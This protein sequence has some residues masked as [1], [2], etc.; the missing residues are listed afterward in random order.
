MNGRASDIPM[1]QPFGLVT[2]PDNALYV[3]EVGSHVIR[4]IDLSTGLSNVVAGCGRKG[5]SGDGG[6]ATSAE[7][8]E[9]YE[10]RFDLDGNMY[11]VE[12][13]NHIVRRVDHSNGVISTIAGNGQPGF[14]GDGG[15]ANAAMLNRPHSIALDT[16]GNLYICDIGNHRIRKVDL[17]SGLIST[18]AGTGERK[19]TPDRSPVSGTP[20]NGPRALDFDGQH[21][22]Y[23]ALREGNA[24]YRIDLHSQ[25]IHHLAGTG[26]SGFTGNGGDALQATLS[27]PKGIC[28]SKAGDIYFADTESHTIRVVRKSTGVIEVVVGDGKKGDGPK[29]GPAHSCRMDR[30][31]GVFVSDDNILYIGD[32][33]NHKVRMVKLPDPDDSVSASRSTN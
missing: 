25:S 10:V 6:P 13:Q 8:N 15:A 5:Y 26:K 30:P 29:A 31:H 17:G 22:L 18:F 23:L 28:L 11:F 4:R 21:S 33:N 20:L 1:P 24:I 16:S 2:G 7:L 14:V 12:M 9:P 3:C 27:G 32:S 19:P